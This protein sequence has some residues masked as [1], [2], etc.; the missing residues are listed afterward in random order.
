M[1]MGKDYGSPTGPGG[2]CYVARHT[3]LCKLAVFLMTETEET[4]RFSCDALYFRMMG[5]RK[6]SLQELH[7][8]AALMEACGAV[9]CLAVDGDWN[10]KRGRHWSRLHVTIEA[11]TVRFSRVDSGAA[12]TIITGGEVESPFGK[13]PYGPMECLRP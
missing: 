2:K 1:K 7:C 11:R 5:I 10:V 13:E 3:Y 9:P 12:N 8:A 4:G 6:P